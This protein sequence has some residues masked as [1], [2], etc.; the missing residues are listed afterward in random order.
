MTVLFQLRARAAGRALWFG[1]LLACVLA[2]WSLTAFAQAARPLDYQVKAQYLPNLGRYVEWT[3]RAK[4]GPEEP[5]EICILGQDPFGSALEAALQGEN[6]NG[7][8]L[9]AKRL[10]RVQ[11]A[12]TCR[13]LYISNS[14]Q[15]KLDSIMGTL[16]TSSVLTVSDIPD[17]VRRG[18]MIQFV[19]EGSY[20]RFEVNLSAAERAG[21]KLS[22]QLLKL[23]RAVR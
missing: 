21:L 14:E 12:T 15:G 8:P 16:G 2:A 6:I 4:P 11:D 3:T 18:G 10:T 17:F 19:L 9:A 23:A 20:V 22:S 5:F 13:V 1:C 7:A